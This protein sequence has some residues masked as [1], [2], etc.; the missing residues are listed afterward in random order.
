MK[1]KLYT[2]T[3][4]FTVLDKYAMNFDSITEELNQEG[5]NINQIVSTT[6]EHQVQGSNFPSPVLVIT[7]LLEK[8]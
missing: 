3:K 2:I 5:W 8:E 4:R 1:Q 6:F 7:L